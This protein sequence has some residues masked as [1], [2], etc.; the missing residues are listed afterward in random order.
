[1]KSP[2]KVQVRVRKRGGE[3][4]MTVEIDFLKASISTSLEKMFCFFFKNPK[5]GN[6]IGCPVQARA[7][8]S[9]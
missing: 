7:G 4:E 8:I 1:M 3:T 2:L 5:P 9:T 6:Q